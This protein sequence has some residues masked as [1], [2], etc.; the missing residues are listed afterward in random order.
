MPI[1]TIF[2]LL[3][4]ATA[5]ICAL[6]APLVGVLGYMLHYMIGPERQ[7]W[8]LPIQSMGLR[9]SFSL[10]VAT[11]IGIV[12]AAGRLKY[13]KSLFRSQELMILIFLGYMW[14][15][16]LYSDKTLAQFSGADHPTIKMAKV[17]VFLLIMTHVATTI[18]SVRLVFWTLVAGA[19]ILG[20][21]AW[22]TPYRDFAKGRLESVGGADF[23]DANTLG[24]FTGAMLP[25]IGVQLLQHKWKGKALCLAAGAF[26]ANAVVLTRSRG[27][28][29]GILAGTALAGFL[30]PKE[31]RKAVIAGIVVAAV[32]AW[33]IMDP[34]YISRAKSIE[35]PSKA[36]DDAVLSRL[37]IWDASLRMWR[38][39]PMGVG[40]GNFFQDIGK[41]DSRYAG[42][43]AHSLYFRCLA[44]LGI[45][46]IMLLGGLVFGAAASLYNT[47]KEAKTLHSPEG[48]QIRL[49]AFGVAIS[50]TMLLFSGLTRSLLYV[51]G[52]WWLLALPVCLGRALENAR[53]PLPSAVRQARKKVAA[54]TIASA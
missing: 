27:A 47:A 26:A 52:F 53:E 51:E 9:Y 25:L 1:K 35:D 14:F 16:L 10:A 43:D 6:G 7:W 40:A 46:G 28:M 29:V 18:K 3:A 11:I 4:F 8:A 41:Y 44:E 49:Y 32:G 22:Q 19:L 48:E 34:G 24:A 36:S 23:A 38:D 30:A 2:F 54:K 50:L 13:G 31:R 39:N 37:E 17:V 21:Q 45:V 20:V 33:F 15:S 5:V 42:R 12:F